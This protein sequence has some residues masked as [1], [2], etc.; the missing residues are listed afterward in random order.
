LKLP[1]GDRKQ[2]NARQYHVYGRELVADG[3]VSQLVLPADRLKELKRERPLP[4]LAG[5]LGMPEEELRFLLENE[6]VEPT[7]KQLFAISRRAGCSIMWLMG[8]HVP[9]S[10]VPGNG[11]AEIISAVGRRN[12]AEAT[13]A[14][15]TG[16]GLLRA[17]AGELIVR[18]IQRANIEIAAA[19]AK[20]VARLHYPLDDEDVKR[21]CGQ[22]VYVE[23]TE[24]SDEFWALSTGRCIVTADGE[25]SL[26]GNGSAYL[27]YQTPRLM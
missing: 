9:R 26:E 18:R 15:T 13:K 24:Q 4:I 16:K 12:A 11:D 21:M 3:F 1:F 17:L 22:P 20:A 14:K 5:E 7:T 8:Y 2:I 23:L 19:A 25:L 10:P 27:V 6:C